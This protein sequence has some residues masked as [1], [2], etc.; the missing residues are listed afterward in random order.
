LDFTCGTVT[1]DGYV[2]TI[3]VSWPFEI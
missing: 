1:H 2:V 3:G